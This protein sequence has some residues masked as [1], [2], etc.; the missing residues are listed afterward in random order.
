MAPGLSG[1][2]VLVTGGTSGIGRATS[3]AFARA[4]ARVYVTGRRMA[5]GEETVRLA[6]E[7]GGEA[8]FA[9][10]DIS[11]REDVERLVQDIVARWSRLD[12]AF[13][14]AGINDEIARTADCTEENWHRTIAV[15]LT[16][17][18]FCMKYEI[19]QMLR[20]RAGVIVNNAS[21][22]GLVGMLG[23]AAYAASKGGVI[24]LT[25]TAA[26]EYAKAG[27]RVNAVC[28]GFIRT[29]IL[30]PHEAVNPD[31]EDWIRRIQPIGRMGTP[32]EVAEAVVWLCSDAGSF[33]IGHPLV[34]D[35]GLVAW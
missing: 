5:E 25:R 13:N 3:V 2:V 23:G 1:K 16:G 21:T 19:R 32:E 10:A 27:I 29:P 12:C 6:R 7:A 34:V 14:N 31:L 30:E 22:A 11:V 20:Q 9:Q 24:Q 18:W 15:N 4:G 28:P 33:I 17:V 26:I 8:C 35:G